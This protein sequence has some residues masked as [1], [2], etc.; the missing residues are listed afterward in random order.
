MDREEVFGLL[1]ALAIFAVIGGFAWL[2]VNDY[3]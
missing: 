3:E 2:V 1:A